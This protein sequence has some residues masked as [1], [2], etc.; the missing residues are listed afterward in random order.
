MVLVGKLDS[1]YVRRVAVSMRLMGLAFEHRPVSVFSTYEQYRK[2]NPVVK[3]PSFLADDGTLLMDSSLI[4]DYVEAV[5]PPERRLMPADVKARLATLR[6]IGFAMAGNEKCVQVH[7]EHTQRPAEK[8][9]GAWLER[10]TTQANAAFE[11]LEVDV[12]G[13]KGGWF[14]GPRLDAADVAV[15]IAWRFSQHYC[16]KEVPAAKYPALVAYSA[17]A[18]ALPEFT[19]FPVGN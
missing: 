2:I 17:R 12:L 18:E 19:A 4:L 10:V 14:G 16:V 5:A 7:Y 9:H 15:A 3:S 8:V 1:P 13:L 11:E 6:L